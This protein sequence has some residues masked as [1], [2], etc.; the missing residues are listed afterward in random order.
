MRLTAS[1]LLLGA[2][3]LVAA[4][5][6]LVYARDGFPMDD[7][8]ERIAPLRQAVPG[9]S[10]K[11]IPLPERAENMLSARRVARALEDGITELPSLVLRDEQGSFAVIPL[12]RLTQEQLDEGFALAQAP[13]RQVAAQS[14]RLQAHQYLFFASLN[15]ESP[16]N[17]A[18]TNQQIARC[19]TLMEH[20]NGTAD[21]RQRLGLLGLYPLLMKRYTLLWQGAHTPESEA[22]L[23][24]AIAA[25]ENARDINPQ[26]KLGRRAFAERERLRMARRTA[27][28]Y[29]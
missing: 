18:Q 19:R 7:I 1:L 17:I 12:G 27:R 5:E 2:L 23:L 13:D 11:L 29:E 15:L 26:N 8:A 24:E 4:E 10:F 21:D 6:F 3:P 25:L 20:P 14:R 28:Q 16:V 22:A 9:A